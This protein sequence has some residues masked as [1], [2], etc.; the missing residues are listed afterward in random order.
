MQSNQAAKQ[1]VLL[2]PYFPNNPYQVLLRRELEA[3]GHSVEGAPMT[4]K[5]AKLVRKK[6]A[7]VV[8][9]HWLHPWTAKANLVPFL[10]KFFFWNAQLMLLKL[11]GVRIAWTLHNLKDHENRSPLIDKLFCRSMARKANRII[12]HSE[13]AVEEASKYFQLGKEKYSVIPHGNYL[14]WYKDSQSREEARAKLGIPDENSVIVAFGEIRPYKNTLELIKAFQK[15]ENPK[16][17]LL[18]AGRCKNTLYMERIEKAATQDTRVQCHFGFIEDDEVQT[19]LK[20]ADLFAMPYTNILTSGAALLAMSFG[21]P[22]LAPRL[23]CFEEVPGPSGAKLYDSAKDALADV[24]ERTLSDTD[25]LQS[26]RRHNESLVQAFGW[27][28]IAVSTANAY[29]DRD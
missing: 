21:L 5:I 17:S 27:S 23:R 18:I 10:V 20:A 28:R 16:L 2:I 7:T 25:A 13:Q 11:R 1:S 26:M 12:C 24:L 6:N 19:F 9:F 15:I 22:I 4:W 14:G 8:H 3:M 29:R